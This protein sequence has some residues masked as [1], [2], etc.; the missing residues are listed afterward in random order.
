VEVFLKEF[1][2]IDKTTIAYRMYLAYC[3]ENGFNAV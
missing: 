2:I 3:E 1:N